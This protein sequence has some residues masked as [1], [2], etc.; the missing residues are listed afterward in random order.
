MGIIN[1]GKCVGFARE[2]G[3]A[4]GVNIR[5]FGA[6]GDGKTLDTKAI[7]DAIEH[8][9]NQGG[10]TVYF[11]AGTY[12]SFSIRL[13]NNIELHLGHGSIYWRQTAPSRENTMMPNTT[14]TT[15]TRIMDIATGTIVL[16]GAKASTTLPS[17]AP[18]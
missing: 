9:A 6:A 18:G 17:Q 11:P 3:E 7:N 1:A 13:K 15:S 8:V 2:M 12:L 10:G 16:Y 4:P 14:R 5:D